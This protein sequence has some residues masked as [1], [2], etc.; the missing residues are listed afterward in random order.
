MSA[1]H[2]SDLITRKK[3][4]LKDEVEPSPESDEN[5]TNKNDTLLPD[6]GEEP[7][8]IGKENAAFVGIL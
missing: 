7:P 4:Q 3:R 5:N 6:K 2:L 8:L 1:H